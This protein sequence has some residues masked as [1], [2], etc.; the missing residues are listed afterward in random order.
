ME[1]MEK[2]NMFF[3]AKGFLSNWDV[4]N[5]VTNDSKVNF[6]YLL[7]I[8]NIENNEH[9]LWIHSKLYI[10]F[11]IFMKLPSDHELRETVQTITFTIKYKTT[12]T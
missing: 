2:A 1:L 7:R 8:S 9:F 10:D 4:L 3:D 11:I 6:L 12:F 5:N